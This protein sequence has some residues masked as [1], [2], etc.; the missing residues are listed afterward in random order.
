MS[1]VLGNFAHVIF[2]TGGLK[3]SLELLVSGRL[4]P[5]INVGCIPLIKLLAQQYLALSFYLSLGS[6]LQPVLGP[7]TCSGH[8]QLPKAQL[9]FIISE[10]EGG[11][12][13]R[14]LNARSKHSCSEVPAQLMYLELI[15]NTGF[16]FPPSS[17]RTF[18]LITHTHTHTHTHTRT[19]TH[20]QVYSNPAR[21]KLWPCLIKIAHLRCHLPFFSYVNLQCASLCFNY[22][23]R[24]LF[25]PL[26]YPVFSFFSPGC[27]LI[28]NG[29]RICGI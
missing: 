24:N 20:T 17:L 18:I 1:L 2:S 3:G 13:W 9:P 27:K 14:L 25:D 11:Y 8:G 26:R 16:S 15:Q 4:P 28:R 23:A 7:L 21:V 6:K 22:L 5:L 29:C 12:A 19:H 10:A